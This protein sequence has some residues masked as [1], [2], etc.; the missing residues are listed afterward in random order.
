MIQAGDRVVVALGGNALVRAGEQPTIAD[1]ASYPN[2]APLQCA[3][4]GM[5]LQRASIDGGG[6]FVTT[7]DFQS[8]PQRGERIGVAGQRVDARQTGVRRDGVVALE[9]GFGHRNRTRQ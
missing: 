2:Q 4:A 6:P 3:D 9:T 8:P 1:L 7:L 5:R